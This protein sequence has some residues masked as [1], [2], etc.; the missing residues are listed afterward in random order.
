MKKSS[1]SRGEGGNGR[2]A[3][4][5][6]YRGEPDGKDGSASYRG[7]PDRKGGSASYRGEPDRQGVTASYRGKPDRKDGYGGQLNYGR[8][9]HKLLTMVYSSRGCDPARSWAPACDFRV[10]S[11]PALEESHIRKKTTEGDS[12]R[13]VATSSA[14][15]ILLEASFSSIESGEDRSEKGGERGEGGTEWGLC[16]SPIEL[17]E[18]SRIV[19]VEEVATMRAE[20]PSRDRKERK[21]YIDDWALGDEEIEG[22]RSFHL[23]EKIETDRFPQCF[24]KEMQGIAQVKEGSHKDIMKVAAALPMYILLDMIKYEWKL[25]RLVA[26]TASE[27]C[28]IDTYWNYFF[29]KTIPFGDP[30]YPLVTKEELLQM[31]RVAHVH[32]KKFCNEQCAIKKK[33]QKGKGRG[34]RKVE[35]DKTVKRVF[36]IQ[37]NEAI[38]KKLRLEQNETRIF[39]Q[40]LLS[41]ATTAQLM[42]EGVEKAMEEEDKKKLHSDAVQKT[43]E[44]LKNFNLAYLQ[45]HG[46]NMPLLFRDKAGLG[47]RVPS[48]NFS[49]NDVRMCVGGENLDDIPRS[50]FRSSS[51]ASSLWRHA[52]NSSSDSYAVPMSNSLRRCPLSSPLGPLLARCIGRHE[53]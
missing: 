24:V 21:H 11:L 33:E 47:L 19:Q 12:A 50:H 48:S 37:E 39:A 13:V 1:D 42:L 22:R 53:V 35:E 14:W 43:V 20:S 41:D 2:K 45:K 4:S 44:K 29:E 34:A 23:D 16:W 10:C 8:N 49:V 6:S 32:Y 38:L 52:L 51:S 28:R 3:C 5:A 17:K 30:K 15:A 31:A 7:E 26:E 18:A 40:T 9:T 46:F 27:T 25:L 36:S